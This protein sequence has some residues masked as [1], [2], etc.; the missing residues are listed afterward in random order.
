MELMYMKEKTEKIEK[1]VIKKNITYLLIVLS[2][3]ILM[4]IGN[5]S[6]VIKLTYILFIV[7]IIVKYSNLFE[8]EKKY[9]DFDKFKKDRRFKSDLAFKQ[10]CRCSGLKE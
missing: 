10:E 6:K 5:I 3:T 7:G 1:Y 9:I 8:K 2:M 4:F